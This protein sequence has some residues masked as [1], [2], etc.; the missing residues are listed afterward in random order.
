MQKQRA[1]FFKPLCTTAIL[2]RVSVF[3]SAVLPIVSCKKGDTG[4][5]GITGATGSANVIYSQWFTPSAYVKDT[6]FYVYGFNYTKATTD[7][8][9]AVIDSG[10]VI[11][12]GKL[13][14]Y[15][16]IIWPVNQVAQLPIV[17]NYKMT[18]GGITYTDTWSA[19]VTAGNLK[20]R[21]VDDQNYYGSIATSHMF[22]Y[23]VIPGGAKTAVAKYRQM[24]YSAVCSSLGIPE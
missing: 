4:P 22:R 23:I 18:T 12:Y 13:L 1:I 5:A 9:Q 8:T 20:I 14:G 15:N 7:I 17:L 6:V 3:L 11:T 24:G 2:F 10:T 16:P 19:W 21:M